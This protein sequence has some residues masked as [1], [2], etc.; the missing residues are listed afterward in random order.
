MPP[1]E[2]SSPARRDE[3]AEYYYRRHLD[4]HELLPAVGIAVGAGLFAFYITRILMQRTPIVI[5][6]QPRVRDVKRLRKA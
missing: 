6:R 3:A 4:L 1:S 5:D 2:R